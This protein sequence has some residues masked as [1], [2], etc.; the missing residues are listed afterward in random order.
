M[1]LASSTGIQM[2]HESFRLALQLLPLQIL[3]SYRLRFRMKVPSP[4]L[5]VLTRECLSEILSG[6]DPYAS[7]NL[8]QREM[9]YMWAAVHKPYSTS[10]SGTYRQNTGPVSR[11]PTSKLWQSAS[12][13]LFHCNRC[14]HSSESSTAIQVG[15]LHV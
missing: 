12:D 2:S 7:H 4:V 13:G 10:A 3:L 8:G 14:S 9:L 5:V 6:L 11:L 15:H 1:E